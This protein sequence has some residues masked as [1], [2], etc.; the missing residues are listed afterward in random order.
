MDVLYSPDAFGHPADLPDA[1][2][3]SSASRGAC[4]GAASAASRGRR[5]I[6]SAGAVPTAAMLLSTTCRPTATRSAPALPADPRA[7]WPAW[8]QVRAAL[9]ARAATRHVAVFVGADHHAAHPAHRPAPRSA[10]R[11]GARAEF[12][13]SR[14]DEFFA[15]ADA[16][17]TALPALRGRAALV[18]PL[19]LDAA[20][21]ARHPR[22]AQAP[23][24]RGRA[25]RSRASPSRSPRSPRGTTAATGAA[26]ATRVAHAACARSFTTR[27]AAAPAMPSRASGDAA[28]DAA[29]SRR[30]DRAREPG[31]AARQRSRRARERPAETPRR[32]RPLEPG[33]APRGGVV[34][35]DVTWFRRDVLVG[36][37][38][39]RAPRGGR[40]AR[41]VRAAR[42]RRARRPVQLLGRARRP[43]A[44]RRRAPLSRSGRGRHRPRRVPRAAGGGF[45]LAT[46]EPRPSVRAVAGVRRAG[47][48]AGLDNGL[49]ALTVGPTAPSRSPTGAADC[50]TP[51]S[52][53]LESGGDV[54][55]TYTYAPRPRDRVARMRPA[56]VDPGPRRRSAGG[57]ARAAGRIVAR[58]RPRRTCAGC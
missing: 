51:R 44:A 25:A 1:R 8:A 4:S 30:R 10:R 46:L 9:V 35:A 43:R 28:R 42:P 22:A 33:A 32:A 41:A 58:D 54:G 7:R 11:A 27:S 19:H 37:P 56:R 16:E 17:A 24:R 49:L 5:A 47:R 23:P 12:R 53:G 40:G 3:R 57:G 52:P 6:S 45:G 13:V 18:L 2:A 21:R 55:D 15:A 14:L 31:R 34:V 38:G 29:R 26:A 50:C 36:P 20:G 48:A 39:A